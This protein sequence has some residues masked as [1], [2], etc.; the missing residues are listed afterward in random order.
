MRVRDRFCRGSSAL[1]R[2]TQKVFGW[3]IIRS[4]ATV[5]GAVS[6]FRLTGPQIELLKTK[7]DCEKTIY[8]L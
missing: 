8:Y 2:V 3:K 5:V 1:T 7:T 4:E 6:V